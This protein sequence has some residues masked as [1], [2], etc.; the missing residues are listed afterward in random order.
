MIVPP[1]RNLSNP[2]SVVTRGLVLW[3]D[4]ANLN[5]YTGSGTTWRDMASD[6]TNNDATL[7]NGPTYQTGNGGVINFDGSNDFGSLVNNSNL[8]FNGSASFS[9]E[10]WFYPNVTPANFTYPGLV[11][12]EG[13]SPRRGWDLIIARND[14][15]PF[16]GLERFSSTNSFGPF[17]E[18]SSATFASKWWHLIGTYD[19]TD[20]RTYV[21]G[22]FKLSSASGGDSTNTSTAPQIGG[23]NNGYFNGK[24]GIVRIY[25]RALAASE[26]TQNF[27]ALRGR[28]GI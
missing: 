27:Q 24:I 10:C 19:G 15:N 12:R 7:T 9:V 2:S 25:N 13:G 22:E 3:L 6:G 18:I 11:T 16:I 4:A 26:V 8:W 14:G 23:W 5:S 21:N 1:A 17:F 20:I 28:Y